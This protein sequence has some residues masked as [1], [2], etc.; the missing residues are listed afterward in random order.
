MGK[1]TLQAVQTR[2]EEVNGL[3]AEL[4]ESLEK[5]N[6]AAQA[7][8]TGVKEKAQIMYASFDEAIQLKNTQGQVAA[9][10]LEIARSSELTNDYAQQSFAATQQQLSSLDIRC[11]RFK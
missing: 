9:S 5:N 7:L 10:V 6:E 2:R 8:L 3:I 4:D 1:D 11:G